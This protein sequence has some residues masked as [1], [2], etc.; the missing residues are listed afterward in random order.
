MRDALRPVLPRVAPRRIEDTPW[1]LRLLLRHLGG[2]HKRLPE[3]ML[4]WARSPLLMLAVTAMRALLERRAS[5]LDPR[6][7][8]LIELRVAQLNR[9][10]YRADLAGAALLEQGV[11]VAGIEA[12]AAWWESPL[13]GPEERTVLAYAEAMSQPEHGASARHHARLRCFLDEEAV[14]E[15]TALVAFHNL[16]S[17]FDAALGLPSRGWCPARTMP[18]AAP[19]APPPPPRDASPR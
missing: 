3:D 11:G 8:G 13:F 17:K 12:V 18:G 4:V 14:V 19:A 10:A 2:R 5:P 9:C 7:R 6:L 15:L 1:Y 16:A